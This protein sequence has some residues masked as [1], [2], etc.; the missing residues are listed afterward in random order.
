MRLDL[1]RFNTALISAF[2][3]KWA[4]FAAR[5]QALEER[6]TVHICKEGPQGPQGER[7]P[8]GESIVGPA[9]KDGRDGLAGLPG[10]DGGKGLDGKDGADGLDGKD[11]ADGLGFEDMDAEY[12]EYGR[13]YHVYRRGDQVKRFR[14]PGFVD[15]GVYKAG[16]VYEK[17]DGASWGGEF[18]IA[19]ETTK[20]KPGTETGDKRTWRLAVRRG[21][22]GKQGQ[23]GDVGPRG[24]KGDLGPR[25]PQG[26]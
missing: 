18:W 7:G 16:D 23:K 4:S 11:G 17:G 21:S 2:N 14:V 24:E 3:S 13:M 19:Q 10:R 25:G 26:Y 9:G 15:R 6:E 22:E 20:A 1:E 12:D 5:L 8:A